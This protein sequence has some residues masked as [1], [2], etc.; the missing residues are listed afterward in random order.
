MQL[1]LC[2]KQSFMNVILATEICGVME[3][4]ELTCV[5]RVR[6]N[7]LALTMS[8]INFHINLKEQKIELNKLNVLND[9]F[10]LD[11][12]IC[13]SCIKGGSLSFTLKCINLL[14]VCHLYHED[15]FKTRKVKSL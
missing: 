11:N 10:Q 15:L 14:L 4:L 1:V 3:A 13:M 5:V 12:T 8:W 2:L 7:V 6:C 9:N